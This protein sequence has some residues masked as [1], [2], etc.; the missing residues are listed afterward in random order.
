VVGADHAAPPTSSIYPLTPAERSELERFLSLLAS[1]EEDPKARD[2]RRIL[3]D[4]RDGA[5]Q[6]IEQGRIVFS[7]GTLTERGHGELAA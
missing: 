3:F 4:G 2:V 7:H 1:A 5:N 6:W